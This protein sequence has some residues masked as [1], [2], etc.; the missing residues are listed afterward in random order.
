MKQNIPIFVGLGALLVLLFGL[1]V[2]SGSVW[3]WPFGELNMMEQMILHSIRLPKALT[4]IMAGSALS[5]AGLIMQT[6]FRNPLAGPYTL[7]VSSGASLGVAFL[8]MLSGISG[9]LVSGLSIGLPLFACL[10][11]TLVLLLVLVVSRRV[12]NNV[13]LLI[14][15]LMFGSIAGALVS[16]LQNFANP[17]A[18]KLFIVWTLGSLSSVGWN[19]MQLL[20]PILLIGTLF[21]LLA[22]KP[23]NGLLLGEDYARGLGINVER[24]RL[25]IVLATGLLAGGV[26]AFCGP[27]AFIGVAVPHIARGI[28][29]SSNHRLTL[30][31]SALIG[32]CLLLLCDVLC[33]LFVYPL[34]ISTVSALFGA[35]V[36]IWIILK[37]K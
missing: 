35:P 8:T 13:S 21:V 20:V 10:G 27:I 33:S 24:T 34:P 25:F 4:A 12:T 22:L 31:A 14:V 16:L 5:I 6:L 9:V 37:N 15:G 7:G 23:L 11:A 1:D 36:I 32:A 30:P 3:L 28:L 17:D 19:D 29:R 2:C 26:T 18:L